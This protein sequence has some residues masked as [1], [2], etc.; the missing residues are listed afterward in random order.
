MSLRHP[1]PAPNEMSY[2]ADGVDSTYICDAH[3]YV[4]DMTSGTHE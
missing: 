1:V 3:K 4:C 2:V